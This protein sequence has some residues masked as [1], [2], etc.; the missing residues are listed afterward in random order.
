MPTNPY[1]PPKGE[2]DLWYLYRLYEEVIKYG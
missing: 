2:G 1:E